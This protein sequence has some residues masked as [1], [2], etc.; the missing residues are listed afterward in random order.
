M[1]RVLLGWIAAAAVLAAVG[2]L[3]VLKPELVP[4]R[5]GS[6]MTG[7]APEGAAAAPAAVARKPKYYR[8]PMGLPDTSPMP[9]KDSMGMD[10]IPV[11]DDEDAADGTVKISPGKLQKAGVRSEPAERR[12]L[13]V[14]V[15]VP[16]TIQL[17]E[18]RAS[19]VSRRRNT[20]RRSTRR[21]AA[22]SQARV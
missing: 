16:G 11:Y 12:V 14:P 8:H 7:A 3:P 19:I 1:K 17:D 10:Y 6:T 4:L 21:R 22:A 2:A 13:N 15:R 20:P 9:K 5:P 18:R